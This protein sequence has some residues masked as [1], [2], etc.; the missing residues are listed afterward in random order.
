MREEP[1]K[2]I[3]LGI[4][5]GGVSFLRVQAVYDRADSADAL[6]WL[7]ETT[8]T[9]PDRNGMSGIDRAMLYR[10][11]VETGLR[12]GELRSLTRA[13]FVLAGEPCVT[14][15]AA[16][17]KNRRQDTVPRKQSDRQRSGRLPG[18]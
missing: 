1:C 13:S 12:A 9:G 5:V 17:T 7:P 15:A 16:Y 6:R 14:I 11:A 4:I 10:L 8:A 3:L 2:G 18:G